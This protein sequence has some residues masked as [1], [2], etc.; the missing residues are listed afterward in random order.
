[1]NSADTEVCG[2]LQ[3]GSVH[4]AWHVETLDKHNLCAFACRLQRGRKTA[5]TCA[6]HDDIRIMG[7]RHAPR[8]QGDGTFGLFLF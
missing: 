6:D 4:A 7:N 1:M 3:A 5:G 8:G 2:T